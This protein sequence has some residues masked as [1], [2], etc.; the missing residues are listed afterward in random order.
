MH[1]GIIQGAQRSLAT[2]T[3]ERDELKAEN[4]RLKKELKQARGYHH[5]KCN[6][7][8]GTG[9]CDC[10]IMSVGVKN[11]A[12]Y[13]TLVKELESENERLQSKAADLQAVLEQVNALA[14]ECGYG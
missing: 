1:R 8:M 11:A 14:R 5:E 6:E 12:N 2:I 3:A 7:F 9:R 4:E 10:W 13:D